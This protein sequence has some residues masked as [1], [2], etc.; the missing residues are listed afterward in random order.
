MNNCACPWLCRTLASRGG[1]AAE[2]S[3]LVTSCP[4]PVSKETA[5]ASRTAAGR[6][7]QWERGAGRIESGKGWA[8]DVRRA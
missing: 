7:D 6:G 4:N 3:P 5:K 8:D 1:L 2:I